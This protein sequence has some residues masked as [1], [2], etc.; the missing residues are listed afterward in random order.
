MT[1]ILTARELDLL[2]QTAITCK[3]EIG[4]NTDVLKRIQ[5]TID[6]HF[7][8]IAE[9]KTTP[10]GH[11]DAKVVTESGITLHRYGGNRKPP[12]IN[13]NALFSLL[14]KEQI[15]A[16][17]DI[18]KI[19]AHDEYQ[20]SQEKLNDAIADGTIDPEVLRKALI[21]GEWQTAKHKFTQSEEDTDEFG[22]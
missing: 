18:A 21:E 6:R 9:D 13:E 10:A 12:K 4:Y 15:A 20:L 3:K 22:N 11:T 2:A 14:K 17:F 7:N 8:A 19:P 16:V 5:A 1:D